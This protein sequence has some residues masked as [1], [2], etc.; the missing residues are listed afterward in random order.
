MILGGQGMR[1]ARWFV[2]TSIAILS[3]CS[4]KGVSTSTDST[5]E[6][7]PIAGDAAAEAATLETSVPADTGTAETTGEGLLP[8]E[9]TGDGY[10][11]PACRPGEGCFLD[12]CQDNGDCLSGWCVEHMGQKVC[13]MSCQEECPQG[14]TCSQVGGTGPDV[15]FV[16]VSDFTALCRPCHEGADCAGTAGTEDACVSYDGQGS[17]C[18]GKC[19]EDQSCPWGFSCQS[20]VTVD[21]VKLEQCVADTG[22]C[23]CTKTAVELGLFTYCESSNE[24]GTCTGK[25]VCTATGLSDCDAPQPAAETCNAVDDNCNGLADEVDQETGAPVCDDGNACTKDSCN[26]E[27][28][29]EH[30]QLTGGECLDGDACTIGDHCEAGGCVGQPIQ[31]DDGDVCTDDLCDGLGGCKTVHNSAACDDGDPCTVADTCSQGVCGGYAID[32]E[33][34]VDADCMA[35]EDETV[36]NGTLLCDTGKLP[37]L[38]QVD[39]GSIVECPAPPAGPD[40]V[41]LKASC[42]PDTGECF[43]V[44]DHEGFACEDGDPCTIGDKCVAGACSA[45]VGLNCNDGNSCTDDSCDPAIGCVHAANSAPC[46]DGNMCTTGDTCEGGG[47]LG[48]EALGCSDGNACNG[49]ESCDPAM[50]CKPGQPLVCEDDGQVCTDHLCKPDVGCVTVLNSAL[51]DDG[52]VCTTGDHCDKGACASTGK[53]TCDDHNECTDDS[54]NAK[55]GCVFSDN[56]AACDDGNACTKDD[57]CAEGVC[58][59]PGA[60][61]LDCGDGNPCTDDLCDPAIGCLHLDNADACQDGDAC[62]IGDTCVG[63]LCKPGDAL[64]CDDGKYCNGAETC[65]PAA[66]CTNGAPPQVD[67]GVVCTLDACEEATDQVT[68]V[69]LNAACDDGKFCNGAEACDKLLGCQPGSAPVLEDG[70]SCTLDACEEATDQITHV[71]QDGAC[72]DGKFCN[73]PEACDPVLNCKAGPPPALDDGNPCTADSCDEGLDKVVHTPVVAYQ[74]AFGTCGQTGY[75]GPSQGQ[76]DGAY[77]GTSLAG[78]V[79]VNS[80]IQVWTAPQSG[81]YDIEAAGAGGG[82]GKDHATNVYSNGIPGKG[83]RVSGRFYLNQGDVLHIIVGQKGSEA[84]G[85]WQK[86]GGGGGGTFVVRADGTALLVAG[87]GGG[88]GRYNGMNGGDG[89][90]G[91]NGTAGGGTGGAGGTNGSGGSTC[92]CGYGGNS[93][94]GFLGNGVSDCNNGYYAKS[95]KSGGQG[96]DWSHCW[97]DGNAGGFGG[98]GGTGPHGGAGGG[99]YSG[100]G[101]GGDHNCGQSGGGGGGGSYNA[102][103]NPAG[104]AGYQAGDGYVKIGTGCN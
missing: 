1:A 20:V 27:D 101:G 83:A 12:E 62:T 3:A 43:L 11:Q 35:L 37:H 36:C 18:G 6:G 93:G 84:L 68:H 99:G 45:G 94:A 75:T 2:V 85:Y 57:T 95:F 42:A 25:R 28:G 58:G 52:S 10:P 74:F 15:M 32:C 19:G 41:C 67:D 55:T 72:D 30:E 103:Q 21:G 4:T 90:T 80:G 13:S 33:C 17:F 65:I 22:L 60:A 63:G 81:Y 76:C 29:C 59:G 104:Q 44:A 92:N 77:S 39:P 79:S 16:C 78:K 47:C 40:A 26:G 61:M 56:T 24:H 71:A 100:G 38:C 73:G 31:C 102:G 46:E 53:L 89:V 87:G 50:G 51:C 97:S 48:G 66:G 49:Q 5:D 86:G 96:S 70:V 14:W 23:P 7:G 88:A 98:G 8:A 54:C 91:P 82:L 9:V 69:P 34:S 64:K